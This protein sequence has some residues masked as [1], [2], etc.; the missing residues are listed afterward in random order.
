MESMGAG[1]LAGWRPGNQ[2]RLVG[3]SSGH[4]ELLVA[5]QREGRE[6]DLRWMTLRTQSADR[7]LRC[8]V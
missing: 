4:V 3:V 1:S 6:F 8:V 5:K 2:A 7:K